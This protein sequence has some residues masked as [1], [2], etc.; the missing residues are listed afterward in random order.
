MSN[1]K[2]RFHPG[3]DQAQSQLRQGRMSRREFLRLA[4]L[5][6]VSLPAA[7]MLAACG[8]PAT[9]TSVPPTS[10]PAT[11]V[12]AVKR[13]GTIRVGMQIKAIDHPARYE[14][15]G[16]DSNITRLINEYLTET[17]GQ[18]VTH[19]YLLEKWEASD[20]LKTWTLHLRQG[21][22]WY[23]DGANIEELVA[24][25][26]KWNFQQW[27]DPVTKSSILGL[28]TGFLTIANVEVKDKYTVVLHLDNPKL[29]V[30]ES[31]FHYPAQILHPTFDGD[32]TTGKNA[33]TGPHVLAE[34]KVG[35]RAK[36]QRREG[37]WQ[38]GVDGKPLTY[39]D[40]IEYIDLGDNQ[41]A[42]LAALQAGQVDNIYDPTVETFLALRNDAKIKVYSI[43]TSDVRVLRFRTN[44]EPWNNNDVRLAV[45]KCQNR[46]K[47]LDQAWFGEGLVGHDT[48]VSPVHPEWAPI[49]APKYDPEGAKELLKKAGK[50][51]LTFKLAAGT[52]WTDVVA[53]A[54]NLKEDAKAA[55]ITV[56]I[57]AMPNAD[58]WNVWNDDKAPAGITPWAHR[59]LAV[60]VL[61]LAYIADTEGKPV[62]WNESQWVDQE[63]SDI[64]LT[65]QGTLDIEA[66]RAL[67]KQLEEI[68]RDRGGIAIAWWRNLW[69]V[70]SPAF[71]EVTPHPSLYN[72][73]REVWYDPDKA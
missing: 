33:G 41:T 40:A 8:T 28:W 19:P 22:Q 63:F 31:L 15:I 39:F 52:G 70:W 6:G 24:D 45:K 23:K 12:S 43:N 38:N 48:H 7:Q 10:V 30:P 57:D 14:W 5:L 11:A 67:T 58:Y 50:E 2:E 17:D 27:L 21:I 44:L 13:G 36:T 4:T 26:V 56:E 55:G 20:D 54:E 64:L 73:W 34:Y 9:A 47:I 69:E 65:A 42:A 29:D 18:N 51:G 60:M 46:Q 49:D 62:A 32:I 53:Y 25:H 66:R 37:Y 71:Q 35:E 59:P 1:R 61:P 16:Q 3:V 68:Q 72:L